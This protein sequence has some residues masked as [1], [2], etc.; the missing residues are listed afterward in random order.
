M[1]FVEISNHSCL[2]S[3]MG[4]N[5]APTATDVACFVYAAFRNDGKA[6]ISAAM[7]AEMLTLHPLTDGFAAYQ[8]AYGLGLEA[9]WNAGHATPMQLCTGGNALGHGGLDYGSG[10]TVNFFVEG[11]QMGVSMMM[12]SA[13]PFGSS[14]AG[15]NCSRPWASL[16][17]IDSLARDS[18]LKALAEYAGMP[19]AHCSATNFTTPSASECADAPSFGKLDFHTASCNDLIKIAQSTPPISAG[20]I[21]EGWLA[22]HTLTQIQA[23]LA[24]SHIAYTPPKGVDADT[25]FGIELCLG[26]CGD[27]GA[28]PCWLR[29]PVEPWCDAPEAQVRVAQVRVAQ[30]ARVEEWQHELRSERRVEGQ[31]VEQAALEQAAHHRVQPLSVSPRAPFRLARLAPRKQPTAVE[32]A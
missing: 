1:T 15:M 32:E 17:S 22:V 14:L 19:S 18:L 26:T 13:G 20:A 4:G 24:A 25:T 21:C 8:L 29:A 7:R 28:G 16:M 9:L 31:A 30:Q 6:L 11:L 10:A 27:A 23:D 5:I 3:W 2:N 12:A